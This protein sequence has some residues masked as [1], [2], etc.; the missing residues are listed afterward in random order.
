MTGEKQRDG[1]DGWYFTLDVQLVDLGEQ[2]PDGSLVLVG[3]SEKAVTQAKEPRR[4]KD[5]PARRTV[6]QARVYTEV[7]KSGRP[8]SPADIRKAVGGPRQTIPTT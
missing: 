7:G 3:A 6:T 1:D 5:T 2:Y 8:I 4:G